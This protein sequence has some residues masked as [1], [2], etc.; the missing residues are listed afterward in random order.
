VGNKPTD[1]VEADLQAVA[2]LGDLSWEIVIRK[3]VEK[4]LYEKQQ[5]LTEMALKL[6]L[7]EERER[8]RI[9]T[10]L[11]DHLSQSLLLVKMKLRTLIG[12]HAT[13]NDQN[14]LEEL[15][16][17]QDQMIRSVRSFDPAAV[18]ADS[19]CCR[20]GGCASLAG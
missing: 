13:A 10:E 18:T 12:S 19:V 1:Y 5:K 11:H 9:A 8:Q 2:L 3:N 16:A 7:A 15:L 4:K 17:L 20:A 6:S 14:M